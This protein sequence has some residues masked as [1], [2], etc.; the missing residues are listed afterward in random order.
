[1]EEFCADLP[2]RV[3]VGMRRAGLRGTGRLGTGSRGAYWRG[4]RCFGT[5]L[6]AAGPFALLA[7]APFALLAA[8][9]F[10][11]GLRGADLLSHCV[12]V[13]IDAGAFGAREHL[14]GARQ[15]GQTRRDTVQHRLALLLQIGRA[16][17]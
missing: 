3:G 1:M 16:H 4:A 10:A 11:Y 15:G 5:G 8:A 13:D 7:A 2:G 14:L 9:P 6:L 17:V 12:S